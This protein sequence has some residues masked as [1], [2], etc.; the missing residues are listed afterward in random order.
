VEFAT[1]VGTGTGTGTGPPIVVPDHGVSTGGTD[2][3]FGDPEVVA[4]AVELPVTGPEAALPW[5]ALGTWL[6]AAGAWLMNF[7]RKRRTEEID[8]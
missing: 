7:A 4:A 3:G 6:L 1:G 8:L 5:G 2:F